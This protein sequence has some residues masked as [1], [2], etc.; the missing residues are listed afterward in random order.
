MSENVHHLYIS[1]LEQCNLNCQMCYTR[2]TKHRLSGTAIIDF[3]HR[4][5]QVIP[6]KSITFCGGEVFLL[7]DFIT[8]VNTLTK[9]GIFIQII[10]NGT[11]NRLSEFQTPNQIN[12]IV[13]LDGLPEYHDK[14]RGIG[15]WNISTRFL[16]EAIKMGFHVEIFSIVTKENLASIPEFE[17]QLKRKYKQNIPITYHPRKPM[18]YLQ[19]HP[20]SNRIGETTHFSFISN[21][22]RLQLAKTRKIFPGLTFN[23]YQPSLMS[24]GNIYGCCEGIRPLGNINSD[25]D[26]IINTLSN[27]IDSMGCV[28][29]QFRCG[30]ET[31]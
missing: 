12:Q 8:M 31:E 28:E 22:E 1:P 26:E 30:L 15:M 9:E 6:V 16:K 11:I 20:I 17:K 29:P 2:K 18:S 21:K 25:I 24:D 4:Y 19:K 27:R 14:N 5:H 23:C 13:S 10:T 3:V 7:D